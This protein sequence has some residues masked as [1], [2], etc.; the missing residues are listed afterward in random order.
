MLI[1]IRDHSTSTVRPLSL[2]FFFFLMI[3][4][5]P[6]STLFPYTTLFRSTRAEPACESCRASWRSRSPRARCQS[7]SEEHTSELQSPMYLVCRLLLEKKKNSDN[8][9]FESTH[10]TYFVIEYVY[11]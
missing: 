1:S 7:R 10:K 3:R 6:R 2:F 8:M 11:Q 5:P 4:R 9:K